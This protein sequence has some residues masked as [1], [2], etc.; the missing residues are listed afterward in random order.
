MTILPSKRSISENCEIA[1]QLLHP[2]AAK[3]ELEVYK[4]GAGS[5]SGMPAQATWLRDRERDASWHSNVMEESLA[6][7]HQKKAKE[8]S[9][10]NLE[11][12]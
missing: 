4:A 6:E 7:E 8:Y 3:R 10:L 9:D 2:L 12:Y 5:V 11:T 1:V